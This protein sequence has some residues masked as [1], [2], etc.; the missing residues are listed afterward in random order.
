MDSRLRSGL[1]GVAS[2]HILRASLNAR[3]QDTQF[4]GLDLVPIQ[5]DL[6]RVSQPNLAVRVRWVLSNFLERLPFADAEF[7]F[8][9]MRRVAR[10]VPEDRW[11]GLFEEITRVLKMGGAFEMVEEDLF[12]PGSETAA[13]EEEDGD[14]DVRE[15]NNAIPTQLPPTPARTTSSPDQPDV[16]PLKSEV[17]G[18]T[19][20]GDK[21]SLLM[22]SNSDRS[23]TP[24]RRQYS[25]SFLPDTRSATPS[26]SD[27]RSNASSGA[28]TDTPPPRP[29]NPTPT[30]A[31]A[32]R[33]PSTMLG[34][35]LHRM[36]FDSWHARG[37]SCTDILAPR[38][39]EEDRELF[40]PYTSPVT[41]PRDHSVLERAYNEMHSARFIN[42]KPLS[43][44]NSSLVL[45]FTGALSCGVFDG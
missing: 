18:G 7:D 16:V 37:H 40:H 35:A 38:M 32:E 27:F 14:S 26:M 28:C 39:V 5:P 23:S 8:V 25:P 10:G 24:A 42:L 15:K 43:V 4:V 2:A 31:H 13:L 1:E 12:F 30:H 11:D 20:G 44:V 33:T 41:N 45:H 29:S 36:S 19:P 3:V 21:V 9:H 17:S 34:E 6:M 22:R